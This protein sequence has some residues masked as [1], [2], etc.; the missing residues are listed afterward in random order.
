MA[1]VLAWAQRESLILTL[2]RQN[3]QGV[4]SLSLEGLYWFSENCQE[5]ERNLGR[6][7]SYKTSSVILVTYNAAFHVL[8]GFL[9]DRG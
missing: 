9:S 5:E 8:T 1:P 6:K 3:V 2:T 4:S 7:C